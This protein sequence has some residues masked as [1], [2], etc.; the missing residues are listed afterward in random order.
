MADV[1]GSRYPPA[2]RHMEI[3]TVLRETIHNTDNQ[4]AIGIADAMTRHCCAVPP[5]GLD[6]ALYYV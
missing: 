2:A 1:N 4:L 5:A 6:V 3:K